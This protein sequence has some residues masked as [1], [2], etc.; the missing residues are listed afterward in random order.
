MLSK[1]YSIRNISNAINTYCTPKVLKKILFLI[2]YGNI[3]CIEV[4]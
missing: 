3:E 4:K 1:S 2:L